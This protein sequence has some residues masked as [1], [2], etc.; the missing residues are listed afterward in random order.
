MRVGLLKFFM[1]FYFPDIINL[2]S[3]C[4]FLLKLVYSSRDLPNIALFLNLE[5]CFLVF[6]L[7]SSACFQSS[8]LRSIHGFKIDLFEFHYSMSFLKF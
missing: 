2:L 8:V 3:S 5:F 6:L 4:F 1:H 7:S